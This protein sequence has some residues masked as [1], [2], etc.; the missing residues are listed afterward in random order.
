VEL[1]RPREFAE[2]GR[3][4]DAAWQDLAGAPGRTVVEIYALWDGYRSDLLR[5]MAD[6]DAIL[7]PVGSHPAPPFRDRDPGRFDYTIPFSLAGYPCVVVPAGNAPGGL[8]VGVQ[9]A[10]RPWREDVALA[11]ARA[12][13][14]TLPQR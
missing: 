5:F 14:Q 8:P 2:A 13:E 7:C 9:I 3:Q 11:M 10:A 6:Y 4:I 12:V 1:A